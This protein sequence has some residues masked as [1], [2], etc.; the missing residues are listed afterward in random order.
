[1][2]LAVQKVEKLCCNLATNEQFVS[3]RFRNNRMKYFFERKFKD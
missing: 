3:T 1:L 2:G